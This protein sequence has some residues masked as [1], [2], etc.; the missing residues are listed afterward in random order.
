MVFP[1]GIR[2]VAGFTVEDRMNRHGPTPR[3]LLGSTDCCG[4]FIS[5]VICTNPSN[6]A[7]LQSIN[8]YG[9]FRSGLNTGVHDHISRVLSRGSSHTLSMGW[10]HFRG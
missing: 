8:F 3:A 4:G 9:T 6:P 10:T 2:L 5:G 1:P 7:I